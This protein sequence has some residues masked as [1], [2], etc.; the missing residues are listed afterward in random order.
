MKEADLLF[1]S[2][3]QRPKTR[4]LNSVCNHKPEREAQ[5]HKIE[6]ETKKGCT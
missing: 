6:R 4:I 3:N 5:I 2:S 1:H